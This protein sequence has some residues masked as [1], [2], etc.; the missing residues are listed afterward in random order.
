MNTFEVLAKRMNKL[1]IA[2]WFSSR[3]EQTKVSWT[4]LWT[5]MYIYILWYH[6]MN[7]RVRHEWIIQTDNR[8]VSGLVSSLSSVCLYAV[9]RKINKYIYRY[10]DK[11]IV[12]HNDCCV[13]CQ[14]WPLLIYWV[15][16]WVRLDYDSLA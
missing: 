14:L 15:D 12:A 9:I 4:R 11:D 3:S 6:M 8:S 1:C 16:V 10:R 5:E 13:F 2:D 7:A